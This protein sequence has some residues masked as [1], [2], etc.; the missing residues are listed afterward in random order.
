[1]ASVL[2]VD[3]EALAETRTCIKEIFNNIIDHS[4]E[5]IG[6]V[7]MQWF[8]NKHRMEI[9]ISDFGCGIPVSLAKRMAF[10]NDVD[11]V[12]AATTEG[13]T[14]KSM[15][16]NYGAGLGVLVDYVVIGNR[17]TVD[18][19]SATGA[20][21]CSPAGGRV[22]KTPFVGRGFYPGTLIHISMRT[23]SLAEQTSERED[24]KW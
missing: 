19:R 6:C 7:H 22:R 14:S 18:I 1:M 24:L 23:D 3:E 21:H 2:G 20:V 17:G 15:P 11:A 8:P 10:D 16:G 4:E 13:V 5:Q 9:T 12:V